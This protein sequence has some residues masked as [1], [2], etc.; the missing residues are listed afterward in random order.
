MGHGRRGAMADDKIRIILQPASD[1]PAV[2]AP[3]F[4]EELRGVSKL[5]HSSG[6]TFSSR[7]MAFDSTDAVGYQ[8]PE[9]L[10]RPGPAVI[11]AVAAVCGAWVQA[12]N[13]RKV[14][15]KIG[16]GTVEAEGRTVEEIESLLKQAAD[17]RDTNRSKSDNI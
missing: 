15:L 9:F 4:Q 17:F 7:G 16:D 5:L 14:W 3:Q 11:T 13:G 6:V 1:D 8:L 10:V 12:R 2:N